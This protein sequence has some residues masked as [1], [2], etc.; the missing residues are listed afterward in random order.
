MCPTPA[1]IQVA[2]S[3]C[4]N[5]FL[6]PRTS[7]STNL[8]FD[9]MC[10]QSRIPFIVV[11]VPGA[12]IVKSSIYPVA[13]NPLKYAQRAKS[14]PPRMSG[15]WGLNN[16]ARVD[17]LSPRSGNISESIDTRTIA[18]PS[19]LMFKSELESRIKIR[20]LSAV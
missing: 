7:P 14:N 8:E 20:C 12:I 6:Y 18:E 9:L 17:I 2:R 1:D 13:V 19:D 10:N 16:V 4:G 11:C 5:V 3:F 15:G